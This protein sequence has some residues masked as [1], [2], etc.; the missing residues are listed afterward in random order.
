M[1]CEVHLSEK[2]GVMIL[3]TMQLRHVHSK[4]IVFTSCTFKHTWLLK[5]A[6][7]QPEQDVCLDCATRGSQALLNDYTT[8][9]SVAALLLVQEAFYPGPSGVFES[10]SVEHLKF[11]V[12][13]WH[14]MGEKHEIFV[15]ILVPAPFSSP[16]LQP[17]RS[18]HLFQPILDT[19]HTCL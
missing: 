5:L 15:R 13:T 16:R 6:V 2:F 1:V 3:R 8:V 4:I 12:Q 9:Q 17:K 10:D 19:F 14:L 18:A 7:S 11:T